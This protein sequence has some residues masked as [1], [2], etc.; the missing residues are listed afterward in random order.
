[1]P[2]TI[3]LNEIVV[4]GDDQTVYITINDGDGGTLKFHADC[5]ILD[6]AGLL[7]Y[8]NAN[9]DRLHVNV[10]RKFYHG[11]DIKPLMDGK[12]TEL[13]AFKEWIKDGHRNVIGKDADGKPVYEVI[14]KRPWRDTHPAWI[15]LQARIDAATGIAQLKPVLKDAVKF[16][17]KGA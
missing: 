10:L 5:P 8:F 6:A 16:A 7:A 1:M 17:A 15:A 13:E 4:H 12:R 11:A 2:I 14:E 3:T 9:K